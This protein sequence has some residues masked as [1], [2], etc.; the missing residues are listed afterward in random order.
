MDVLVAGLAVAVISFVSG[1][2]AIPIG[3][4]LG[5]AP[6]EVYVASSA[7]SLVGL[8]VFLFAGDAVRARIM[9][10]REPRQP[11]P[12]SRIRQLTD[13]YGAK[14]LGLV[15]PIFP[16]VTASVVIGLSLGLTRSS[17]AR[18]MSIG[19]A[20]MFALYTV[21]MWLL[22]ELIGVE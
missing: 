7:G 14:G 1:G 2:F 13:R 21:G 18:W 8:V 9:R 6:I 10:N 4:A 12:D 19:I 20:A 5:L 15:G 11:D 16:G 17:I 22:V 3:F